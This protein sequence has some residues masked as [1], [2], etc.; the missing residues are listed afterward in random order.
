MLLFDVNVLIYAT[1]S[2][3]ADHGRYQAWLK[4]VVESDAAF[5]V[6]DLVLSS[7][8]R[9]VTN[10]KAF[11]KP[12]SLNDAIAIVTSIRTAQLRRHP[13]GATSL[14][15]LCQPRAASQSTR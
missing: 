15:H 3:S 11:T 7:Y 10:R 4:D 8:L 13:T 14:G 12:A 9:I 1:Y 6:A 5:G 2:Q